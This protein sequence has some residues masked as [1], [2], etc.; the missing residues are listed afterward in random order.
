MYNLKHLCECGEIVEAKGEGILLDVN[1]KNCGNYCLFTHQ[2]NS[3]CELKE[4]IEHKVQPRP[5][6]RRTNV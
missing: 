5:A 4:E 2:V 3:P 6:K 1:C